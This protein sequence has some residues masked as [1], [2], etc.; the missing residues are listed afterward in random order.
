[1]CPLADDEIGRRLSA[2]SE[3]AFNPSSMKAKAHCATFMEKE[4]RR[5]FHSHNVAPRRYRRRGHG[6][7]FDSSSMCHR[8][9]LKGV[10]LR[11]FVILARRGTGK[12][13]FK[14]KHDQRR[15][16]RL[17]I[18]QNYHV[19]T[20]LGRLSNYGRGV[21]R[22]HPHSPRNTPIL[23]RCSPGVRPRL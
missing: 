18:S 19:P 12:V 2:R 7:G 13:Q 20:K 5:E 17:R 4:N 8:L 16:L 3:L 11:V 6:R 22:H 23:S 1:M 9:P 10:S 21:P 14:L 15:I